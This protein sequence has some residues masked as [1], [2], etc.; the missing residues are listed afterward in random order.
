RPDAGSGDALVRVGDDDLRGR[1]SR[2]ERLVER[3]H[4]RG[5]RFGR[6]LGAPRRAD[7]QKSDRKGDG[8]AIGGGQD[9]ATVILED[10]AGP[11]FTIPERDQSPSPSSS[12]SF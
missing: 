9:H 1:F 6:S 4:P 7:A 11:T 2:R 10:L 12:T 8:D 3:D 5:R